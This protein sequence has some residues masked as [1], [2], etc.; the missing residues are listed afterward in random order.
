M[1]SAGL[2]TRSQTRT[3]SAKRIRLARRR[4]LNLI[5]PLRRHHWRTATTTP[6][7]R[8]QTRIPPLDPD[9]TDPTG[10]NPGGFATPGD[11]AFGF[12][13]VHVNFRTPPGYLSGFRDYL[14]F[15]AGATIGTQGGP[16]SVRWQLRP[17]S[18]RL[19]P[20]IRITTSRFRS[21]ALPDDINENGVPGA[22][23][24]QHPDGSLTTLTDFGDLH[25]F[26]IAFERLEVH[27][28]TNYG[29]RRGAVDA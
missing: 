23:I 3:W 21:F 29:R 27:S 5:I 8:R 20:T 10:L 17:E 1:C 22:V 18:T 28:R 9:Y 14:N 25:E 4:R 26:N 7:R 2:G 13:S 19:T 11:K 12:G 24:V 6:I 16:Q 15:L